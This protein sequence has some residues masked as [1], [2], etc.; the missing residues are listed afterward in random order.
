MVLQCVF[1]AAGLE[2]VVG[3]SQNKPQCVSVH[4]NEGTC[5]PAQ[6]R[7]SDVFLIV[8]RMTIELSGT[9]EEAITGFDTHNTC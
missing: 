4:G 3:P 9:E 1:T 6:Q 7:R 5:R 8:F 2:W